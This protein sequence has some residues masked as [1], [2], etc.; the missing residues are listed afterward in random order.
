MP[1]SF[2]LPPIIDFQDS[3]GPNPA[4]A[5]LP[6]EAI[7]FAPYSK[8]DKLGRIADWN[9]AE[10]RHLD[11]RGAVQTSTGYRTG[12]AGQRGRDGQQ[13]Y[14][15]G[16]TNTFAYFHAEDESSF[17]LVDNKAGGPRRGAQGF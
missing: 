6:L 2:Y 7:P 10:H 15:S 14:G 1:A 17:S 3:W 11:G 5:K 12:R 4:H 8:A 16:S 9:E 13:A